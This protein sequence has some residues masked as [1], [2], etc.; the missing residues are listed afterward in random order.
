MSQY[1]AYGYAKHGWT[2]KPILR[3]YYT[4]ISF[5]KT[6]NRTVRVL[7]AS[8]Q[9]SARVSSS[10]AFK[11]S[12]AGR[13]V[14]LPGGKVATLTWSNSAYRVT[15]GGRS[16]V[17]TGPVTFKPGSRYPASLQPQPE[18]LAVRQR[19]EPAIAATSASFA[20]AGPSA[21]SITCKLEGYLRGVVPRES[22]SSWPREALRAQAVRGALLRRAR[23]QGRRHLRSLLYRRQP[24]LQRLRRRGCLHQR[25]R[26]GDSR[27]RA[28]LR[29]QGHRRL[30]L[31]DLRRTHREHRERL[32]RQ[33]RSLPQ[34]RQ[35]SLRLRTRST[36]RG[37]MAPTATRRPRSRRSSAVSCA[38]G[39]VRCM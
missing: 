4:G 38:G 7:L 28:H 3:H 20:T 9:A 37:R 30:L 33:R 12:G 23:H 22:P 24:G 19:A 21:S 2:Y 11:A 8:G 25:R 17:F 39:R 15:A 34:E 5:G 29:W 10:R 1:G 27:R 18:R 14:S 13:S 6:S 32:G 26:C 16:W 31:L 35:R 36:T